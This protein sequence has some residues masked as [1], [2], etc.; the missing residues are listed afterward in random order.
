MK[1]KVVNP[2]PNHKKRIQKEEKL[3]ET[4][5]KKTIENAQELEKEMKYKTK[6]HKS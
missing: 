6:P 5:L 3:Q 4:E 1:R 2:D